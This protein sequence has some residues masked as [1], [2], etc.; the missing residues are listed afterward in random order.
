MI[1]RILIDR[2][3][4]ARFALAASAKRA[5]NSTK[6][7]PGPTSPVRAHQK[8]RNDESI[9]GLLAESGQLQRRGDSDTGNLPTRRDTEMKSER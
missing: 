1:D 3:P 9:Q 8:A 6:A 4:I 2:F 7:I 5:I